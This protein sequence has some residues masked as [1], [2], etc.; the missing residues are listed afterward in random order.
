[1]TSGF[2]LRRFSCSIWPTTSWGS[3]TSSSPS[4]T[5][6]CSSSSGFNPTFA[7]NIVYVVSGARRLS[8]EGCDRDSV[9]DGVDW[10]LLNTVIK[11]SRVVYAVIA[12]A[13]LALLATAGSAYVCFIA[14]GVDPVAVWGFLGSL[15][16]GDLPQPVL[17]LVHHRAARLRRHRRGEEGV[18][19]RQGRPACGERRAA[20]Y[21]LRP[22]GGGRQAIL[23][24]AVAMRLSAGSRCSADTAR[25]RRAGAPTGGRWARRP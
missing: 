13:V 2:I 17:P 21:G 22:V 8:A 9:G 23:A 25:S 14:A 15:L 19:H 7:R 16:R 10:H 3:G 4:P 11:A 1:M 5:S 24:N 6:P 12:L 18:R 20:G